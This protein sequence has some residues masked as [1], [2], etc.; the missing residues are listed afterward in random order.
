MESSGR[1]PTVDPPVVN[2]EPPRVEIMAPVS[3]LPPVVEPLRPHIQEEIPEDIVGRE[4]V[5]GRE[6]ASRRRSI[7]ASL[8]WHWPAATLASVWNLLSLT[9]LLA[10]VAAIPIVQLVSLGYLLRAAANLSSGRSWRTALPG[11]QL[12]GRIA[13]FAMLTAL[14][15]LPVLLVTDLSYS[16]QLLRPGTSQ[17]VAWRV[18]AFVVASVWLMW[19]TWAAM[20]GGRWW[21]MLWPRPIRFAKQIWRRATW[22]KAA[23]DL[24]A[25]F[26]RTR[27]IELWWL[28][29]RAAAG[30]LIWLA[31]PVSMMII[32]LRAE[33]MEIAPL[34]GLVGAISLTWVMLFLP[35]L[36]ILM[37][38]RNRFKDI[39]S[40]REVR[41]RFRHAPL[42]MGLSLILL[43]ALSI[44]LYLLRIE[45]TPEQLTWLPSLFF[46]GIM[47]PSK[48]ALGA[49]MGYGAR[50][51]RPRNFFLRWSARLLCVAASLTYVGALYIAQF[52]AWEGIYVMYFQHAVLVP[53]A[54]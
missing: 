49:A 33:K 42:A 39:F 17:A 54:S 35:F 32:G 14:L 43:F 53:V 1:W 38:E 15:W 31:I 47:F 5:V 23:D 22:S 3:L 44:P 12:A 6:N 11:V 26:E 51:P 41:R 16:V 28:G 4:N 46:V 37:A 10:V 40:V 7:W 21:H 8:A 20:R 2:D 36:Q 18:A 9:V 52:I 30:A 48:L 45:A 19:V 27:C 50:R 29:L 34:I 24:W 13:T 25:L